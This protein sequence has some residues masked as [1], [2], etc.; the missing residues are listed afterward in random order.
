MAIIDYKKSIIHIT[1]I[2]L[3]DSVS[4][5][6]ISTKYEFDT[7]L[8]YPKTSIMA[9]QYF[10]HYS[11]QLRKIALPALLILFWTLDQPFLF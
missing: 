8:L 9:L 5:T 2:P 7:S 10:F 1:L 3:I 11:L 4:H 6:T